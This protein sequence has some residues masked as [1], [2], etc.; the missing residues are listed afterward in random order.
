MECHT[1]FKKKEIL[2]DCNMDASCC[3][4]IGQLHKDKYHMIPLTQSTQSGQIHRDSTELLC[5]AFVSVWKDKVLEMD[6]SGDGY[7]LHYG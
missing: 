7:T 2:T 3:S 4:E 6:G 5:N 1:A